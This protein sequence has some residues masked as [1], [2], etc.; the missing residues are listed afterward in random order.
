MYGRAP[1][2]DATPPPPATPIRFVL[3]AFVFKPLTNKLAHRQLSPQLFS[4]NCQTVMIL[5]M[6]SQISTMMRTGAGYIRSFEVKVSVLA[7]PIC[8]WHLL[9]AGCYPPWYHI[10]CLLYL[11]TITI[12]FFF[13]IMC[14]SNICRT[15]KKASEFPFPGI[16]P[17]PHPI[18]LHLIFY[19]HIQHSLHY[20]IFRGCSRIN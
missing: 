2:S 15:M 9:V 14:F 11:N 10:K 6:Y 5:Y 19:S 1:L 13:L 3:P 20:N 18:D 4:S 7:I 17:K 12:Q 16:R 8:S